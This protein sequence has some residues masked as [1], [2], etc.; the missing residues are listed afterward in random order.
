MKKLLQLLFLLPILAFAQ[1]QDPI[2]DPPP[3]V[4]PIGC[5][6]VEACN[7]SVTANM[8]DGSCLYNPFID[9]VVLFDGFSKQIDGTTFTHSYGTQVVMIYLPIGC[10]N[11]EDYG[12]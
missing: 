10:L 12:G 5:T 9:A 1:Y 6:D 11:G 4:N 3:P 8:D 7:F 2:V